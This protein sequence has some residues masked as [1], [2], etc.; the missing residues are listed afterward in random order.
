MATETDPTTGTAPGEP[1]TLF[2]RL[3]QND[4]VRLLSFE[5]LV[6]GLVLIV[7][8]P[9]IW[10]MLSSFS[11]ASLSDI[12]ENGLGWY[13]SSMSLENYVD[14]V[15][16]TRF[17]TWFK[18]SVIVSLVSTALS[19]VIAT[20]GG[21]SIGRLRYKGRSAFAVFLL[22]TQMFPY[23]VIIIPLFIIFRNLGL[24]N[25]LTGLIVAYVAFTLPFTTWMLRGFFENLPEQLEEA[26]MVDGSTRVGAVVRVI[27]PLSAPAV[28]TTFIF[29]WLLA[30]NEFLF[31]LV[32]INDQAL[33]TLP[34]GIQQWVG[35]NTINWGLIMAGATTV[36]VPLLLLFAFLQQYFVQGL[37]EGAVK[38]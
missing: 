18:N 10:M 9:I 28:A 5:G 20:F 27:L 38:S 15:E 17:V 16:S 32:L 31:A 21:Y 2:Q 22:I 11:A 4:T 19:I 35:Q 12:V 3:K 26:A 6:W 36:T 24:F 7:L 29:G 25:S 14:M 1:D 30:W 33:K 23:A 34:P 13:L 8:F 37:A